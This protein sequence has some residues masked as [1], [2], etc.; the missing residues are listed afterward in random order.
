MRARNVKRNDRTRDKNVGE[1]SQRRDNFSSI[2]PRAV[3]RTTVPRSL[4]RTFPRRL[5]ADS[6]MARIHGTIIRTRCLA[7]FVEW[8]VVAA[9]SCHTPTPLRSRRTRRA[10]WYFQRTFSMKT[11]LRG[12]WL[13]W[14]SR[15]RYSGNP[16]D[17]GSF[18]DALSDRKHASLVWGLI[19]ATR[20]RV[21]G[22]I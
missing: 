8:S 16:F 13:S 1:K 17:N 6:L 15:L 14:H 21:F 20:L 9:V 10:A 2:C 5:L 19:R 12:K 11:V 3:T 4:F 22:W 7:S 18:D